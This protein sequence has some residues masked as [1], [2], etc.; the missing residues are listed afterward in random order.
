MFLLALRGKNMVTDPPH[1]PC[2][3]LYEALSGESHGPTN[4]PDSSC[5]QCFNSVTTNHF[6]SKKNALLS[7]QF[8]RNTPPI[9]HY[10][11]FEVIYIYGYVYICMSVY[12][13]ERYL[14]WYH[15]QSPPSTIQHGRSEIWKSLKLQNKCNIHWLFLLDLG[16]ESHHFF[17]A[18]IFNSAKFSDRLSNPLVGVQVVIGH[19]MSFH[20]RWNYRLNQIVPTQWALQFPD[21]GSGW[22]IIIIYMGML[23]LETDIY[24]SPHPITKDVRSSFSST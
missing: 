21:I 6:G 8:P 15:F 13:H 4:H 5:F 3:R 12:F 10:Y 2:S 17:S 24:L 18:Q 23:K 9:N 19:G 16:V 20:F 14:F 11:W 1:S 7:W 22:T